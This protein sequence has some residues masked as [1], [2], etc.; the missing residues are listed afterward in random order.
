MRLNKLLII[1]GTILLVLIVLAA[2]AQDKP[3]PNLSARPFNPAFLK[4]LEDAK[5]GNLKLT[6]IDGHGLGGIPQLIDPDCVKE[7]KI[8][9]AKPMSSF[10]AKFDELRE[11]N[12]LTPIRDQKNCGSCWTFATFGSIESGLYPDLS[13]D[14]SENNLKNK[15]GFDASCCAGGNTFMS[16]AYLSRW[17]GP[18]N[19]AD[20]PYS[21]DENNCQSPTGL[22]VR[23]HVQEVIWFPKRTGDLDNDNIKQAVSTYGAAHTSMCWVDTAYNQI[24]HAYYYDGTEEQ[25][26]H[27][28]CIVGWDDNYDKNN[29]NTTPAG[30]G[31]FIVRN[32]WGTSWGENGYFYVSYYDKKFGYRNF[33]AIYPGVEETT[34]YDKVYYY[35]PLGF[36]D[37]IGNGE[38]ETAWFGNIFTSQGSE[39][40]MAASLFIPYPNSTFEL[41]V[42]LDPTNGPIN[43]GGAALTQSGSLPNMGYKTIVLNTPIQLTNNQKFSVIFK[44]TTPGC[45]YQIPVE[46][47]VANFSSLASANAGESYT[48]TDGTTF[49]DVTTYE[50][51]GEAN[52]CVKAFTKTSG[53]TRTCGDCNNDGEVTA[54]DAQWAFDCYL[55]KHT[56]SDCDHSFADVNSDSDVTPGDA[57]AIFENYLS[58]TPLN[59]P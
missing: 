57:Q 39:Q 37:A 9:R 26:G 5:A 53:A 58:G 15:H 13:W 30:N 31:A 34:N 27:E 35:D 17:D 25:G 45:K 41:S 24:T 12:K 33:L 21:D 40:L 1:V 44:L 38:S 46:Y 54:G 16:V 36:V 4:Y 14:F 29:F 43:P 7:V 42:Y 51:F 52:V 56:G 55:G 2:W 48:S 3:K 59:C 32:S 23:K 47:P 10:P 18:M 49:T 6:T 50:G 28:V 11:Q 22:M 19:E 20:D 8:Q